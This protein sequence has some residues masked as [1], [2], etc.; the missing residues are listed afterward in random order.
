MTRAE[1]PGPG[2][3]ARLAWT[4]FLFAQSLGLSA[5]SLF[6]PDVERL[7]AVTVVQSDTF[8]TS[9]AVSGA[10]T[11]VG[12]IRT[13]DDA[14]Q[15][16]A[17]YATAAPLP[18]VDYSAAALVY[19]VAGPVEPGGTVQIDRVEIRDGEAVV[20]TARLDRPL[21]TAGG[22]T[23]PAH[24]VRVPR[25]PASVVSVESSLSSAP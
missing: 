17:D 4:G 24:V 5:C 22:G 10:L 15:F 12:L 18:P 16:E 2:R 7:D 21:R 25:L 9:P 14:A 11:Q 20:V 23:F 19:V 1:R 6:G 8:V 13:P 3:A